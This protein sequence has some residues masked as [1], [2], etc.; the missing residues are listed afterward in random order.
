MNDATKPAPWQTCSACLRRVFPN[1]G[2]E[3]GCERDPLVSRTFP[4]CHDRPP[5]EEARFVNAW[6]E[7]TYLT[8]GDEGDR[9]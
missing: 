1:G 2:H 4:G 9:Q 7:V 8:D 6:D 5:T 3:N